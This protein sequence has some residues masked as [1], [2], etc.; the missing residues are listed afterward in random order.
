[1]DYIHLKKL[2]NFQKKII[3]KKKNWPGRPDDLV[4]TQNP[5]LEPS[6]LPG[7]V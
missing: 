7:R 5:G 4:K 6:R 3:S 2:K 1:M